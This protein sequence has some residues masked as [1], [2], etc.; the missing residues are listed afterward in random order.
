MG[1]LPNLSRNGLLKN[2]NMLDI[3]VIILTYNEEI[4]IRRCL[5]NVS[6]LA[7]KVF[8]VD[9]PSTDRTVDICR[10]FDN[11]EVVVHKYP[12]NQAEQFNWALDNLDIE[13]G[14]ILRLD[15][16]EYLTDELIE[17][18]YDKLPNVSESV[19]AFSLSLARAFCG[20]ILHHS[21]VNGI[22]IT[23]LFR[24]G[25]ARYEKRIMDEHLSVEGETMKMVHKF[26]DDNRMSIGEFT[27]KHN[28]YASR[29]AALLLD[30]EYRLTD[31]EVLG[32]HGEEVERK[33]AQKNRYAKLPLFWR[34]F[35]YFLYRYI[36]KLGFLDGKEGFLWDFL[37]GWWYRT[38][39]DAKV[40]EIK[41]A[42]GNDKSKIR[43]Y[44]LDKY[45]ITL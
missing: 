14:W 37:Q 9:S 39:V 15:A 30:A 17:E 33:R 32:D 34:A 38:L 7:R 23:R 35:G 19:S 27:T 11:V 29:E 6:P 21:I 40:F 10:E 28:G 13:T 25:K 22:W 3:T 5:E 44:L 12:G 41:K 36:I 45:N 1:I 8:V 24:T 31:R 42:C 18:L 20:R 16:D 43:Q 4:H 2:N 26:V